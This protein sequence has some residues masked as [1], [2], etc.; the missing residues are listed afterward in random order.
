MRREEII[1]IIKQ[2][3]SENKIK[4]TYLFGSFARNEK[5]DDIDIVI[6]KPKKFS[7]L[8]LSKL[9]IILEERL[10]V[11][12]DIITLKSLHPKLKGLIEKEMVKI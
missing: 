4:R 5:Y 11:N 9:A 7:L 1:K 10:G 6:E 12:V 2:V 3:T 8:D